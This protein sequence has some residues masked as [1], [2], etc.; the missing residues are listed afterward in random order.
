MNDIG[1]SVESTFDHVA[2]QVADIAAAVEW[3]RRTIP[4]LRVLRQDATWAFL[5]AGRIR[6][7]FVVP[8]QHPPHLAWRVADK[9]LEKL[10]TKYGQPIK[11]HR[12]GSRSFYLEGPGGQHVEFISFP[13]DNPYE[14]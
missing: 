6:L 10:A 4:G 14:Q 13:A 8:G 7:A 1:E 2:I 11:P 12:D 9:E 5:E 3:Y